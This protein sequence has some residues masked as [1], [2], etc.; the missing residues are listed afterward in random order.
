MTRKRER[1][2]FEWNEAKPFSWKGFLQGLKED[3]RRAEERSEGWGGIVALIALTAFAIGAAYIE[4]F[5]PGLEST[6]YIRRNWPADPE[7]GKYY[8]W[9]GW[10]FLGLGAWTALG[11]LW[12][13]GREGMSAARFVK[14]LWVVAVIAL[15]GLYWFA[16]AHQYDRWFAIHGAMTQEELRAAPAWTE[17]GLPP[18]DELF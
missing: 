13:A 8:R 18:L 5:G 9:I 14:S 10:G 1:H 15:G 7:L 17:P 16:T 6:H 2:L 4:F 3:S 12:I 11:T